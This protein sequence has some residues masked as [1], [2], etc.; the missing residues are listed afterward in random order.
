MLRH[1]RTSMKF[2]SSLGPPS[3]VQEGRGSSTGVLAKLDNMLGTTCQDVCKLR[4]A[5]TPVLARLDPDDS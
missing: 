5:L 2:S 1:V 3:E 4:H